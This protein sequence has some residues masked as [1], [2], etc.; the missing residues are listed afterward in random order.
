MIGFAVHDITE[1]DIHVH[2][3][4]DIAFMCCPVS[5]VYNLP[6]CRLFYSEVALFTKYSIPLTIGES[7]WGGRKL[8]KTL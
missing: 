5:E 1:T 6:V 8:L 2:C 3:C 4:S 7:L